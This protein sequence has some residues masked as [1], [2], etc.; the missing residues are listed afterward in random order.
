MYKKLKSL[1]KKLHRG[2]FFHIPPSSNLNKKK[3]ILGRQITSFE[4]GNLNKDKVFYIIQRQDGEG[5]I[6][7]DL[8]FVVNHLKIAKNYGFIPIVDMQ[9]FPRWYNE[10][11]KVKK[12]FNSWNYYFNPVSKY[13]LEEVYKSKNLILTSPIFY[14]NVDFNYQIQD[15]EELI[16]IFKEFI[17]I[18]KKIHRVVNFFHRKYFKNKKIL[19]VH[20]RGTSYKYG[21]NPYPAT[22]KQMIQKLKKLIK[23]ENY[24]KVFLVTEDIS[25]FNARKNEF[26]NDLLYFKNIFRSSGK[27]AFQNYPRLNHRYKLGRDLLVETCLLSKCDG[28]LDTEGNVRGAA[29]TMNLNNSQKRYLIDNGFNPGIPLISNYLWYIKKFLPSNFG[30]FKKNL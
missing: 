3:N 27:V 16:K 2:F 10:V 7:S 20:F 14:S 23:D 21:R 11:N 28:Y 12:T 4:G 8:V 19:G 13:S 30:G 26:K 1:L 17:Q 29:L 24:D 25:H 6:F 5:G 15:S 18:D 9:N 22:I